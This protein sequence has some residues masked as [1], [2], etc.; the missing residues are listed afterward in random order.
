M[1]RCDITELQAIN[2]L[3]GV[4]ANDYVRIYEHMRNPDRMSG[5]SDEQREYL[6]WL[7]EKEERDN[8]LDDYSLLDDD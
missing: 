2:I 7:A 4:H 5:K 6:E 3:N 1:E 8:G